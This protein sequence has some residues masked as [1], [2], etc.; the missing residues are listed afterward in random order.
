[1]FAA[2]RCAVQAPKH[3]RKNYY[4]NVLLHELTH[5]MTGRGNDGHCTWS[6]HPPCVWSRQVTR[7]WSQLLDTHSVG[8]Y[9]APWHCSGETSDMQRVMGYGP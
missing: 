8:S 5:V 9:M 7:E 2:E 1:M 4:T 6:G 3:R